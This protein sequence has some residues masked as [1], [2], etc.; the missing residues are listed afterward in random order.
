MSEQLRAV[1]FDMDDTGLT[2]LKRALPGWKVDAVN[3]ATAR[4]ANHDWDAGRTDLLVVMSGHEPAETLALC[5]LLVASS[6]FTTN[7]EEATDL[8]RDA[9][10]KRADGADPPLLVLLRTDQQ[11]LAQAMLDAGADGCLML[12]IDAKELANMLA[13]ARQG[14]RPGRHTRGLD[15]AQ[16]D[17]SW[18][19]NGGQG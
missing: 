17:D 3:E 12:P 18:R 4:A 15:R 10:E 16:C 8:W 9:L 2:A 13:Q 6:L 19:D 7:Q 1:T 11:S 5:R 14:N